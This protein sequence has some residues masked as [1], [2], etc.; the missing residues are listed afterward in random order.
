M[1]KGAGSGLFFDTDDV[2]GSYEELKGRGVEFQGEP[3]EQ[4]YGTDVRLPRPVGQPDA[5]GAVDGALGGF[6]GMPV[7]VG[8]CCSFRGK[9]AGSGDS[10]SYRRD[11]G[12]RIGAS[13]AA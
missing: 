9:D 12:R 7:A 8:V 4:P 3:T 2:A 11:R 6:G 10:Q 5:A 13:S 1:A